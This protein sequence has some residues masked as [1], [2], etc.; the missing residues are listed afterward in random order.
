MDRLYKTYGRLLA[1]TDLSFTR[2]QRLFMEYAILFKR[3]KGLQSLKT[4][5]R[6]RQRSYPGPVI[7][8]F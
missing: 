4:E 2:Y 7:I 8:F 1:E 6:L 5:K 3:E